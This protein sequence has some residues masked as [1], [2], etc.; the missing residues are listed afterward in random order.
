MLA[1][2]DLGPGFVTLAFAALTRGLHVDG[3]LFV[4]ALRCLGEG[5]LHDVL[6]HKQRAGR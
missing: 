4:D 5:Q 2:L 3:D 6:E 1:V